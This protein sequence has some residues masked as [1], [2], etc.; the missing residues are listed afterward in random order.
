M[1]QQV[2]WPVNV[3]ME[4]VRRRVHALMEKLSEE[5][6][7]A[8]KFAGGEGYKDAAPSEDE[9]AQVRDRVF[10]LVAADSS[11]NEFADAQ[12]SANAS[13]VTQCVLDE[14]FGFGPL[15]P[16]LRDST[17]CDI[18]VDGARSVFVRRQGGYERAAVFFENNDH[19]L[20]TIA[21]ILRPM[22]L[23]LC[24]GTPTLQAILPNGSWVIAALPPAAS[25][26][27]NPI[28][29]VR[30]NRSSEYPDY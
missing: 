23:E 11:I 15:G 28:L 6:P 20:L 14:I 30:A 24:Q 3:D 16:V 17:V 22:G 9:M 27:H 4:F 12:R 19:L 5:F 13:V 1:N 2:A 26:Q 10:E 21:K 7:Q 18:M 29:I 8:A 25:A